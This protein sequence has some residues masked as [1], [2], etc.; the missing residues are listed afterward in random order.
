[1]TCDTFIEK[2][3]LSQVKKTL[4]KYNDLGSRQGRIGFDAIK[5]I[6]AGTVV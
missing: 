5:T 2:V 4:S 1:M 6:G 3:N